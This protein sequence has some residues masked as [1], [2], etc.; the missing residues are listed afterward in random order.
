LVNKY[1]Q[2]IYKSNNIILR[3]D[4]DTLKYSA[5]GFPGMDT[6]RWRAWDG[7]TWSN[8]TML[9]ITIAPAPDTIKPFERSTLAGTPIRFWGSNFKLNYTG[10]LAGIRV[11]R[12]P[13]YG[14][15][16]IGG[17]QLF[18]E[19][20]RDVTLA[21]LD[22]M[23]Y[24][25]NPNIIG[26]DTLQWMGF[27]GTEYTKNDTP[28]ILR[29]YP[30]LNTPPILRTLESTYST[31]AGADT[32]L[33]ANYPAPRWHT[34]V[35]VMADNNRVLPIAPNNTFIIAP[36]TYSAGTHTLK[37]LFKHK[38]DSINIQRTFTITS[39]F[40]PMMMAAEKY[41]AT[42]EEG[43]ISAWPNPFSRQFTLSGLSTSGTYILTLVNQQGKTIL[44]QRIV[45]QNRIV[46]NLGAN[47]G[48]GV[49]L[50]KILS[51]NKK[52]DVKTLK[53]LHL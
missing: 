27:N 35:T 36:S 46:L 22:S 6:I 12:L 4:L 23:Y 24:T 50:L 32:I 25:P 8:D 18:Y 33:I 9:Y 20:S 11:N 2:S 30:I 52:D 29:I 21:E 10:K 14:K 44:Q 19:R 48:N 1:G 42:Q 3:S 15:L 43:P 7:L 53:L 34:D 13:A 28:A 40:A 26:T 16:T 47:A 45:H 31:S 5:P 38:L 49:Y 37:V 17:K 39:P 41:G 51:E